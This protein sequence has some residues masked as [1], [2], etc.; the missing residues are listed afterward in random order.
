MFDVS[1]SAT[2]QAQ[3]SAKAEDA[4]T[5]SA[6]AQTTA[7]VIASAN[8]LVPGGA[9]ALS[10]ERLE[11]T[12]LVLGFIP[13]TDCASLAVAEAHGHFARHGLDVTLQSDISWANIRD[14]IAVG[15]YHGGQML[16][17]M[18]LAATL[19]LGGATTP[20]V[21]GLALSLNGNAITLAAD[22]LDRMAALDTG[23]DEHPIRTGPALRR[24]LDEDRAAGA[25]P[26]VFATVFPASC[27]SYLLRYWLAASGID[28]DHDV[29]IVVVPPPQMVSALEAGR[30]QGFCVGEPWSS[31]AVAHGSGRIAL[32]GFEIWNNA[33][34][35]VL[36]V[37]R[38]WAETHPNTHRA[39]ICALIEASD[40]ADDRNNRV[41]LALL[42][43]GPEY[44]DLAPDIVVPSLTGHVPYQHDGVPHGLPD[45]HVFSRYAAGFPF[46]SHADWIVSQMIRWGQIDRLSAL[47][48]TATAV[49]RPDLYRQA[50]SLLGRSAPLQDGKIEGAHAESWFLPGS[51][52]Q[53]EMGPDRFIDG[54]VFDPATPEQYLR[55]FPMRRFADA[56]ARE[57][58][59][60]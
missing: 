51:L 25:K 10:G 13:L 37:T 22:L 60:A 2:T 15:A 30:I 5:L 23:L 32:S 4:A 49:Y 20:M 45:C 47:R 42:L 27:H 21:T 8:A 19:G 14:K 54:A 17:P 7:E 46:T 24:V 1:S 38:R 39:L 52:E 53:I 44:L 57:F 34:E 48:S 9:H 35:K 12:T 43:A 18:P 16:A 11:A 3:S 40:W 36:G 28:P 31:L 55:S 41:D 58:G 50:A 29:E 33:P 6:S 59:A 56:V 26:M